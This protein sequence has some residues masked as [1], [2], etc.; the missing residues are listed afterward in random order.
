MNLRDWHKYL[1]YSIGILGSWG[2][3]VYEGWQQN[4]TRNRMLATSS[5]IMTKDA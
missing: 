4:V 2:D 5:T 3:S 1:A